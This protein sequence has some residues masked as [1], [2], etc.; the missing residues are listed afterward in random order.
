MASTRSKVEVRRASSASVAETTPTVSEVIWPNGLPIAATGSPT[1]TAVE[2]PS[3]TGSERVLG[4]IDLQEPDV[5]ERVEADHL[6]RDA[7]A[8]SNST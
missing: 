7:L 2:S 6:G 4:R 5:V 1:T 8:A 3:G